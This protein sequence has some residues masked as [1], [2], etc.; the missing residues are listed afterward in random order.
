V[1]RRR[2]CTAIGQPTHV[3]QMAQ[4]EPFSRPVSVGR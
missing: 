4:Q 3:T 2:N 1:T